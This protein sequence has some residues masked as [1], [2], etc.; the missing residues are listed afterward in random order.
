MWENGSIVDLN[1]L[2]PPGSSLHLA[3]T[4]TIN[5]RGE[6]AGSGADS[7]DND[8]AFLLIPCDENHPGL[9]GC[10]YDLVE[11]V[12]EAQVLPAQVTL[13]PAASPAK[14][15]P[16]EMMTRF[17]SLRA[18]RNRRLGTPQASPQ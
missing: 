7:S 14:L 15:S 11:A 10:N 12:T 2:I 13:A 8:H 3:K 6:I 4:Y 17:R 16:T 5:D 9:E 1:A 18:G